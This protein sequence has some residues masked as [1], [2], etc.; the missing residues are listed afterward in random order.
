MAEKVV[1]V[2]RYRHPYGLNRVLLALRLSKGAWHYAC[3]R[4]SFDERHA[5]LRKAMRRAVRRHPEYGY[6]RLHAEVV[7]KG[8]VVNH[9]VVQTAARRWHFAFPRRVKRPLPGKVRELLR[10][11]AGKLNLIARIVDPRPFQVAYTDFTQLVY[12]KGR[13]RIWLVVI[14]E[15]RSRYILGWALSDTCT[16]EAALQAWKK[17]KRTLARLGQS[18]VGM[19]IHGDRDSSY[20]STDWIHVLVVKDG[21]RVSYSEDGAKGNTWQESFNG[22]FKGENG[23]IFHDAVDLPV[24]TRAVARRVRYYNVERRHSSLNYMSPREYLSSLGETVVGVRS[25][26]K[27]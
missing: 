24:L 5:T 14:L 20:T 15:A 8:L 22:R 27:P 12:A 18:P 3:H 17:A 19:I 1:L 2:E 21:A 23:S 26:S 25:G 10:K 11:Q 16:T 13:R 9:K 4:S 7:A 6:R